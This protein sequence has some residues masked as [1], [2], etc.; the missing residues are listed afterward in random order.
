M[1]IAVLIRNFVT[2]GGAE[3]YAVEVTQR[4]AKKHDI[5]VFCQTHDPALVEGLKVHKVFKI[6]DKPRWLNQILFAI[7]CDRATKNQGFDAIHSHDRTYHYDA[8]VVHCPCYKT[9]FVEAGPK[10]LFKYGLRAFL[11]LRHATYRWLER[12]QFKT[13]P[14]R[15]VIVVSDYISRNIQL[16]Y[17][18]QTT[19]VVVAPPGVEKVTHT[20]SAPKT[21]E[22]LEV[23]FVGTEFKR[24]GLE[25]A[26]R[27]FARSKLNNSH[28][29]IAGG[30]DPSE[31][32]ALAKQLGIEQRVTF[33]GLVKDVASLYQ[34]SH[35]FL[36]PTVIEPF[37]MSPLEAMAYGLPVIISPPQNN[38]FVE[39]LEHGEAIVLKDL[40]DAQEIGR[41]IDEFENLDTWRL[42]SQKSLAVADRLSWDST[43]DANER[44]I[45]MSF[46]SSNSLIAMWTS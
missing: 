17:P 26:L 7:A 18:G 22:K 2:T 40:E 31:F 35:L 38:G 12:E 43:T 25:H 21:G 9:K 34:K 41:A 20:C 42:Y 36:F 6:G 14:Q 11:S 15:V 8:Y 16:C 44:A 23:L 37:G 29:S 5:T 19:K 4:L 32:L 33:L 45:E 30:G 46:Q 28:L 27:G 39:Q 13:H 1:K 24:K 10:G 3:R